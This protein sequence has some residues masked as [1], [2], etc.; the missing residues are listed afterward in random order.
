MIG[1]S[2]GVVSQPQCYSTKISVQCSPLTVIN[3]H[4]VAMCSF[5]KD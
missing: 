2:E 1:M 5:L 4:R 3:A